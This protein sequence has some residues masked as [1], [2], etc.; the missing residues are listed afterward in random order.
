M[1]KGA[2]R[3][4]SA[5][6]YRI[7]TTHANPRAAWY[8]MGSPAVPS[9]TQIA[10]LIAASEVKP[11]P[12]AIVYDAASSGGGQQRVTVEMEANSAVMVLFSS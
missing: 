8:A 2:A 4:S 5:T 10:A 3:A 6:E 1:V 11:A 12:L 7:D 9:E